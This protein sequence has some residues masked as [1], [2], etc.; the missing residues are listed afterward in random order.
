MNAKRIMNDMSSRKI[1]RIL[2]D[3]YEDVR[4]NS[5]KLAELITLETG[6]PIRDS[7]DEIKRSIETILSSCGGI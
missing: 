7:G 2:Y 4:K 6:K 3:I 5:D 1:S